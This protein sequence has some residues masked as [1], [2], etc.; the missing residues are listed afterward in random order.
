M[1]VLSRLSQI[2]IQYPF[3]FGVTISTVKTS[4]CDLLVQKVIERREKIDWRRNLAFSTFGCV[5]LGGV[6][7]LLYVP[8]FSRLFPNAASYAAKPLR[9]KIRDVKG[10]ADLLKQVFLDQFIH[11]PLAY[12]PAFYITK[13]LVTS[14]SPDVGGCLKG[15]LSHIDEDLKALWKIWV[16]STLINFAFMPMWGRIPWVAGTSFI[17]TCVLSAMRGGSISDAQ[18]I[19][20]GAVTG[21]TY[22]IARRSL[23]DFFTC[24]VDLDGKVSHICLSASGPDK[25]GW[26]ALLS[27]EVMANGGSVSHS[28]MLRMGGEFAILMHV[29]VD[30]SKKR[31]LIS[32]LLSNEQ[33]EPLNLRAST[34]TRRNT[35]TYNPSVLG[36]RIHC[37][38]VDGTHMLESIANKVAEMGLN[39]ENVTTE[40]RMRK[41]G[42]IEYVV[43]LDCC[44][45][46]HWSDQ[47]RTKM[48]HDLKALQKEKNFDAVD[49]MLHTLSDDI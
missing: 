25:V 20:G 28:K 35:G 40:P 49:I 14:D 4:V 10:T 21:A 11:H 41:N 38:G 26:V 7:Y 23:N 18:D 45:S 13:E 43:N 8:V 48:V 39:I 22:N 44:T 15:Y 30:P 37:V 24:P 27:S 17:W 46:H 34:L 29:S 42:T 32:A 19:A 3:A 6:Q 1:T 9:E 16:P 47:Q 5:Y 2:P 12:F 33:L 31:K 36:F